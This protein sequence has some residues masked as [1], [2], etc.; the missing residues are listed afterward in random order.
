MTG[1]AQ[2][3]VNADFSEF[4][5]YD[6][7]DLGLARNDHEYTLKVWSP[8]AKRMELKLYS[9]EN[10]K[11]P[12]AS[13][14]MKISRYGIWEI[15]FLQKA[16]YSFYRLQSTYENETKNEVVDPYA[17]V[18]TVNGEMGVLA[19]PE[20][21]NPQGWMI[22]M[23]PVYSSMTDMIIY[24]LH[25]RDFS[26]SDLSGHQS[27]GKFIA[28]TESGT[29][30]PT[31]TSTGLD[32][33]VELGI[34]H[35]HLLPVFDFRSIDEA[36]SARQQFNWGYDP[37]N[38]NVP[39]GS[40][41]TD[42]YD[43]LTRIREFKQMVMALHEKGIGVIM[44]VVYNHTGP[45]WDSNFNQL[46]PD[47]YY[48]Q[49][50]K[51][52]FSNA[53]ACGNETASERF[54]MRKFMIESLKYWAQEY[55]IDGF[56]FDL[57]GIHDIT[58]MNEIS[59]ELKSIN[60]S[61]I[62][63]GEGWAAGPSPLPEIERAIKANTMQL[64]QI[65][66]FSDD[67]RDG[68]KGSVFVHQETGFATGLSKAKESIKFGI[69]GATQHP[70][71]N[72]ASVNYSKAPWANSPEQCINYVSCHDNL[73]LW[74]KINI[75]RPDASEQEKIEMHKLANTIV[76]TS[77]G[78]PFLHGGVEFL[79]SKN[80]EHNSFESPDA[81]NSIKWEQK[82]QYLEV[83]DY[84]RSLIALRKAHPAFRMTD[85]KVLQAKLVFMEEEHPNL[86]GYW[87]NDYANGD[88]WE[89]IGVCFNGGAKPLEVE[90]PAGN[91]QLVVAE[92][93]ADLNHKIIGKKIVIAPYSATIFHN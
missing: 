54:M 87:L 6:G 18:V 22:D 9:S 30:L 90:L 43:P 78:I 7:T 70:Q 66:A 45:T 60:P 46:V 15:T 48:R 42:P 40:Y 8:Y 44:D 56:R 35:V 31:G 20:E 2:E 92:G 80:G 81:I 11:I 58:T 82:D 27:K 36:A 52:G 5:N 51:G 16:E 21:A 65:A 69:V 91:W 17:R 72:Y 25:V 68:V 75:S 19:F 26:I 73:T 29:K 76:L 89:N 93:K 38:Y 47:Y 79:R 61:I 62:L 10:H 50:T 83:Y 4:L 77:Q 23:G 14:D 71:I 59:D 49:D 13:L 55:H 41:S 37:L 67:L 33:L 63:Y 85:P 84:Y 28:F 39:E 53:S 64:K 12:V 34:T 24:E 86:L 32:H 1:Y 88:E 74:D 3:M 57:M